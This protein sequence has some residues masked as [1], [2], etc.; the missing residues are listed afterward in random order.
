MTQVLQDAVADH[1]PP[2]VNGR[3]IKL[4]YAH[5]GGKNPPTIVIHGKQSE[6]LPNHYSR[7][8]EKTFR[9][10]L[11]LVGTPVRIELRND[12]NPYVKG[13][14]HLTNQQIARKRKIKKNRKFLKR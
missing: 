14:E 5:A 4:R 12:D 1:A 10:N 2:M 7:Y 3:R 9:K 8:L 6:K 11:K 13:E